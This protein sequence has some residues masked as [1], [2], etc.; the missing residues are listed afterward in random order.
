[1]THIIIATK[2]RPELLKRTLYH[3]ATRTKTDHEITVID[4]GSDCYTKLFLYDLESKGAI[5]C[6]HREESKGIAANIRALRKLAKSDPFVFTDDDVLCPHVKPDWLSRL[7]DG[8]NA[9]PG[10]GILAL[11]N[12]QDHEAVRGDTRRR[13][14]TE[15]EVTICRNV[16]ATL[17]L[18]RHHVVR[19]VTVADGLQSPFKQFCRSAGDAGFGVGYLT[20]TYCQHI[21]TFS[22]RLS[23]DLSV[24]LDKVRPV[25][26][27]TLEPAKEFRE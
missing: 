22:S 2:S 5:T 18:I 17:A 13:L 27:K 4:D 3:I 23:V 14:G 9:T 19:E 1:M 15:G 10:L 26:A 24:D 11:N 21:G 25:D 16:G 12:P 7:V 6:V 8:M 20:R